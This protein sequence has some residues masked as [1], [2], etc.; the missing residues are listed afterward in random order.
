MRIGASEQND[1]LAGDLIC[2]TLRGDF[3]VPF[4]ANRRI[5]ASL[6]LKGERLFT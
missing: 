3:E 5:Q 1:R 4:T 2:A 6:K